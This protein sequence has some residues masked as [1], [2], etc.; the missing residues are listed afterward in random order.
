MSYEPE[1]EPDINIEQ[2]E[3]YDDE[4][5]D[6]DRELRDLMDDIRVDIAEEQ[7]E[8]IEKNLPDE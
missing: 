5:T 8:E 1:E 6:Q 4:V 2:D 3:S 7:I